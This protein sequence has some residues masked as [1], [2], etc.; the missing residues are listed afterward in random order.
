ML[1]A[2]EIEGVLRVIVNDIDVPAGRANTDMTGTGWHQLVSS[3]KR[4]GKFDSN[5]ADGSGN[6]LGDPYGS[7]AYLS[8]VVPNLVS[9]GHPLPRIQ[10]LLDGLKLTRFDCAGQ[11]LDEA[12][13]ANPAWVVLD[14]LRRSGWEIEEIDTAS[15]AAAAQFCDQLVEVKM[16]NGS[17]VVL[18]KFQT[19][20]VVRSR[21]SASELIRGVQ[22]SSSLYLSH[23]AMGRLQ[24]RVGT[25][26]A[27]QQP[28][29]IETSNALQTLNG[30]W[31]A[32]EFGDGSNGFSGILRGSGGRS[33]LRI[34]SRPT[35]DTPNRYTVEFQDAF[36]EYQQDSVSLVDLDDVARS[37][38][39]VPATLA[40]SG[41]PHAEQAIRIVRQALVKSTR[42]NQY[43]QFR[44]SARAIGIQ[45]GDII[46]LTYASAGF[47]RQP[48]RVVQMTPDVN[49]E[50]VLLT[51]QMHNDEWYTGAGDGQAVVI[52]GGREPSAGGRIPRP[53]CGA[54]LDADDHTHFSIEEVAYEGTDGVPIVALR[55]GFVPPQSGAAVSTTAPRISLSAVVMP[56][57]GTLQGGERFFYG[58]TAVYGE[59]TESPLSFLVQATTDEGSDQYTVRLEGIRTGDSATS[60]RIYRGNSPLELLRIGEISAG[61]ATFD[62]TGF[63]PQLAPPPDPNYNH[64][65]FY[66]RTQLFPETS[67]ETAGEDSVANSRLLLPPDEY[68]SKVLVITGGTDEGQERII[69]TNSDTTIEIAQPWGVLP[70]T[71]STFAIVEPTWR[72][73]ASS[74][75]DQ[76]EF[77]VPNLQ[78]TTLQ[79]S[80]R[81]ANANDVETAPGDSPLTN[82]VI[83]GAAGKGL[84][85]MVPPTPFFALPSVPR[86]MRQFSRS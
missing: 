76:V 1:A 77:E 36:N 28:A 21:K 50:T 70:D 47:D 27:D 38:Q 61:T 78:G 4:D 12:F 16:P 24:L 6:P 31:P 42:G 41:F 46:S 5:F 13:T 72:F 29:Q 43:V 23:D 49:Y 63:S 19:N 82:W 8:V 84:D 20:L 40:A 64:A 52:H 86:S 18:P 69:K 45:P 48:F 33:S 10:V 32:Y 71:S 30:G 25:T 55:V 83:G 85:L 53:L 62:D 74:Y 68:V 17:S 35:S 60:I 34:W 3:G 11:F 65:N 51:A 81:A 75:S 66:W 59:G 9:D 67:V 7:L 58:V 14:M 56:G 2:G 57:G 22:T 37:G 54:V 80:G 73:G 15:F 44:T 79:I 26:L 39:E